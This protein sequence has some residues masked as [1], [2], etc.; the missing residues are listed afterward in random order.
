MSAVLFKWTCFFFHLVPT[1]VD[2]CA[3]M[4]SALKCSS[5]LIVQREDRHA[6]PAQ[7]SNNN[8]N[9]TQTH[10]NKHSFTQTQALRFDHSSSFNTI[11]NLFSLSFFCFHFCNL[12]NLKRRKKFDFYH[13][14]VI[15]F[16]HYFHLI[17]N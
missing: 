12:L 17:R 3:C 13:R 9:K 16:S 6:A 1:S 8:N 4:R 5:I 14:K 2:M 10:A 7:T 15:K 11:L